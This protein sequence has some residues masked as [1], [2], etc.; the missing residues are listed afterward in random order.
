[1]LK[2]FAWLLLKNALI[3]AISLF[4]PACVVHHS[5]HPKWFTRE[6]HHQLNCV[7][8][9]RRKIKVKPTPLHLH[10]LMAKESQ[11]QANIA[12]S[13][14]LFES[15]LIHNYS[16]SN[17]SKIFQYIKSISNQDVLPPIMYVNS[18][19]ASL[20]QDKSNVF[21][22]YFFSVYSLRSSQPSLAGCSLSHSSLSSIAITIS[23]VF[24]A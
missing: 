6:I 14:V 2:T 22:K 20:D 4:T 3:S 1:M 24:D 21:N 11:L 7:R 18:A 17:T 13:K 15:D 23:D 16:H 12:T 8:F 10:S 19:F 9:L 5:T